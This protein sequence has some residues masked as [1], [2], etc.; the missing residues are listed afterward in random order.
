VNRLA[1]FPEDVPVKI[2]KVTAAPGKHSF[3][4]HFD[5]FPSNP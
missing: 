2:S 5:D 3:E 4:V 1:Y